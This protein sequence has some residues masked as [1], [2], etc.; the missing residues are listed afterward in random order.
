MHLMLQAES[1]QNYAPDEAIEEEERLRKQREGATK[2]E[3][4]V[5]I[6]KKH[7]SLN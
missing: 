6:L 4:Q 1:D 2:E 7:V 5:R 3:L